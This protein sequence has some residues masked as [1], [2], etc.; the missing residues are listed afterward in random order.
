MSDKPW[1]RSRGSHLSEPELSRGDRVQARFRG[2]AKWYNGKVLRVSRDGQHADIEYDDGDTEDQV[3]RHFIRVV[4]DDVPKSRLSPNRRRSRQLDSLDSGSRAKKYFSKG[5]KI[6]ARYRGRSMWLPGKIR[7]VHRGNTYDI[8]Y[9]NGKAESRVE[10]EYVRPRGGGEEEFEVGQLVMAKFG[11]KFKK[12]P[13]K[14]THRHSDGT[15]DLVYDDGD[16][17][18]NVT[19]DLIFKRHDDADPLDASITSA[20]LGAV[21]FEEGDEV[22]GRIR[23]TASWHPGKITRVRAN[24]TYDI[25]YTS[26]EY[27]G[28]K[29]RQVSTAVLRHASGSGADAKIKKGSKVDVRTSSS[30]GWK[31]AIVKKIHSDETF[32]VELKSNGELV[33]RVKKS[34]V[35]LAK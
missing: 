10:H 21:T 14:I 16:T 8:K 4:D 34:R 15:F 33:R 23:G 31:P 30:S 19:T 2:R 20:R 11:G 3:P 18:S 28:R 17:E 35:R 29:E 13:A 6:E 27:E 22:E 12:Y 9:D 26:G 25:L 7:A 32:T 5:D 24:G 1:R